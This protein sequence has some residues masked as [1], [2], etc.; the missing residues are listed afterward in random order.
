MKIYKVINNNIASILDGENKEVIVMGRGIAF[1]KKSGDEIDETLIDKTFHLSDHELVDKCKQLLK[2]IPIEHFELANDIV[3]LAKVSMNKKF[4]E[5]LYISLTD[6]IY[7]S[8]QRFLD[9]TPLRNPMFWELKRFYEPEFEVGL[10]ALDLIEERFKIRLPE[11]EAGFITLHIVDSE[12]DN[13]TLDDVYKITKVIHDI[14][15]I[16]KYFFGIDFDTKSVYYYRF[17]THIRFFAQRVVLNNMYTDNDEDSLFHIIKD[18]YVNAYQCVLKIEEYILKNFNY[19]IS[20]D[21][22]LYL[23]IHIERI[24]YKAN[25]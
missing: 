19:I 18:K 13:S 21:E 22:K 9:G 2:D 8:I 7:M 6:H 17:I 3:D 11:D 4:N 16:V 5:S 12:M 24:V 14:S 20:N 23:M 1:K 10:K 25:K 15:N